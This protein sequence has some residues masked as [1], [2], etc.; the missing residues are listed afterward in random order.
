MTTR[1]RVASLLSAAAAMLLLFLYP[2]WDRPLLASGAYMYAPYVPGDLDLI[3]QLK[4][5]TLV[6]YREGAA[7]TVSV[8]RLTGTLSL[9]I[10]GKTDL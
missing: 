10:D 5:G 6:Y 4:A 9:A 2:A 1:A 7:A 8:K 3:T